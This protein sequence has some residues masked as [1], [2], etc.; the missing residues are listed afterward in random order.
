MLLRFI[1]QAQGLGFSL[2]EIADVEINKGEHIVSCEDA[3][4][5]LAERHKAV[6]VLIAE[7]DERKARIEQLMQELRASRDE[8]ASVR[9]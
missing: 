6:T 7:A 9:M 4:A 5:L 1:E 8:T 3:L 2:K